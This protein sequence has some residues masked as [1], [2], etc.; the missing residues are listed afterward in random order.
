[1]SKV[2][3]VTGA[4]TGVGR[5]VVIALAREGWD[6]ALVARTE[7]HLAQTIGLAASAGGGKP[8][9]I[10]CP[11]DIADESFAPRL[12]ERVRRELGEVDV[13]VNNAGTNVPRRSLEQLSVEDFKHLI[14]VNLTGAF[15]L[16]HAFLP[17]MRRRGRGTIVNVISDAG[18]FANRGSGAAYIASKFGLTGLTGT[19]NAE[20]R[21]H[22][23]RACGIYPG[24]I[25]TPLLDKR[26][27][28]PGA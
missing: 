11:G 28:P 6:A 15:L 8:N 13:L 14:D 23:I 27:A 16:T 10:A 24:E 21:G 26:P 5:A 25:N 3:V 18:L 22:G 17:Q 20:E 1:M 12:A 2:A 4:G 9:L 19:I 7:S